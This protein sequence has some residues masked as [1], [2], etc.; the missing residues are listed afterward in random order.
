MGAAKSSESDFT[1]PPNGTSSSRST[2]PGSSVQIHSSVPSSPKSC[3]RPPTDDAISTT[4]FTVRNTFIALTA[5]MP[6]VLDGR[7][8]E[9]SVLSCPASRIGM[10]SLPPADFDQFDMVVDSAASAVDSALG[11]PEVPTVGSIDHFTGDCKPCAFFHKQGCGNGVQCAFCH[12]CGPGEKRRRQKE[13]KSQLRQMA[14]EQQT[15]QLAID[16][17]PHEVASSQTSP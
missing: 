1:Q 5:D 17:L 16:V 7:L 8:H 10:M 4:M 14:R 11:T 2:S 6:L 9:R 15:Q 3:V 13:K 12:L